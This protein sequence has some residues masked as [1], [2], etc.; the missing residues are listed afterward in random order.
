LPEFH[1]ENENDPRSDTDSFGEIVSEKAPRPAPETVECE[2]EPLAMCPRELRL[3]YQRRAD[4]A[5][6]RP[7][8]AIE[9]KCLD[10]V[11]WVYAEARQCGITSCPLWAASR[12]IFRRGTPTLAQ[13]SLGGD[14]EARHG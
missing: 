11:G 5:A 1:T 14:V 2:F 3:R 6:G 8:T 7:M 10:C 9:L 13:P 4:L 12:R